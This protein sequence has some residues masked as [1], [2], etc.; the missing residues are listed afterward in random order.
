MSETQDLPF[1]HDVIT[2]PSGMVGTIREL[3]VKDGGYMST[4]RR[5]AAREIPD[6]MLAAC[7]LS[8]DDFGVYPP[9]ESGKPD[10]TNALV[11]DR[12]YVLLKISELSYGPEYPFKV[13][14]QVRNC[15]QRFEWEIDLT[16]LPVKKLPEKVRKA[17]REQG[18]RFDTLIP[19]TSRR[20]WF[21]L[22]THKDTLEVEKQRRA[23]SMRERDRNKRV[24]AAAHG[25]QSEGNL[26]LEGALMRVIDIEGVQGK[27]PLSKKRAI[28]SF[29]E[30]WSMRRL[31]QL[32]DAFDEHDCGLHT[33]IEVEC[34]ECETAQDVKLPFDVDLFLR[35][36]DQM[37]VGSTVIRRPTPREE[38][39]TTT[40][41]KEEGETLS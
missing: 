5:T 36:K 26:I 11:G 15:R 19:G 6:R 35:T 12:E 8:T 39:E 41:T 25:D 38:E 16:K 34:P 40:E 2:T 13:Q 33:T 22:P 30:D 10:W 27:D 9:R 18:N 24:K 20:V 31:L 29:F 14:C 3:G 21:K 23:Q 32:I 28:R 1:A 37:V 17:F 7:W 4:L